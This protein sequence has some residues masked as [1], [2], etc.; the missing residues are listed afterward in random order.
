MA[1]GITGHPGGHGFLIHGRTPTRPPPPFKLNCYRARR[2]RSGSRLRSAS[3][4]TRHN[5]ATLCLIVSR[6]WSRPV[7][8]P[9]RAGSP[10]GSS[11]R[12]GF[13]FASCNRSN[14][15]TVTESPPVTGSP[16]GT[17]EAPLPPVRGFF[18]SRRLRSALFS[19][20]EN[21]QTSMLTRCVSLAINWRFGKVTHV[22][23]RPK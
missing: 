17:L 10:G 16:H 22:P 13:F 18:F 12:R 6:G 19:A 20:F 5:D 1:T 15:R 9:E 8:S 3:S 23:R 7:I 14:E 4:P 21:V 11:L 2:Y